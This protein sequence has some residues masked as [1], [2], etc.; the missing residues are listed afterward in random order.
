[1]QEHGEPEHPRHLG[2][3]FIFVVISVHL[4]PF[5]S[6]PHDLERD[7]AVLT[8]MEGHQASRLPGDDQVSGQGGEVHGHQAVEGIGGAGAHEIGEL[9]VDDPLSGGVPDELAEFRAGLGV[10]AKWW[11]AGAGEEPIRRYLNKEM[12]LGEVRVD[13][14]GAVM[15][16]S[17]VLLVDRHL[18]LRP[19]YDFNRAWAVEDAA[20]RLL[21]EEPERAEEFYRDFGVR[22]ETGLGQVEKLR[23]EMKKDVLHVLGEDLTREKENSS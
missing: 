11:F 2:A 1:M 3:V 21:D 14:N 7:G 20:R 15:F 6:I 12:K 17:M 4:H 22:P 9:L 5:D 13:D 18:H 19:A 8:A 16:D 23:V 10:G